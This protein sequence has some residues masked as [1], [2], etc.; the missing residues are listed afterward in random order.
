MCIMPKHLYRKKKNKKLSVKKKK[1][2]RGEKTTKQK[3]RSGTTNTVQRKHSKMVD[4]NSSITVITLIITDKVFKYKD[5]Q[6]DLKKCCYL[7]RTHLKY[8]DTKKSKAGEKYMT[9]D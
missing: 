2:K 8:E 6:T 9:S 5:W 3:N 1:A 4:L 7:K